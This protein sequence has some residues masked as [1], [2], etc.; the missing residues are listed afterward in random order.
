MQCI[1]ITHTNQNITISVIKN[2][3]EVKERKI[4]LNKEFEKSF[5]KEKNKE[6]LKE[7]QCFFDKAE[8]IDDA[9]LKKMI[10]GQML[11]CDSILTKIAESKFQEFYKLGYKTAKKE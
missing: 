7:L 11:K 4:M 3:L 6:Y 2:I 5:W 1:K 8:N 10:I 9:E